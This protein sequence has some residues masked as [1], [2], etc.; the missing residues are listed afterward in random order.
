[1][2]MRTLYQ[3][4]KQDRV[5]GWIVLIKVIRRLRKFLVKVFSRS[6]D[7][8]LEFIEDIPCGTGVDNIEFDEEG[9]LWIGSHPSLLTFSAYHTRIDEPEY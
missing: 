6:T 7:G 4:S 9:N 8:S 2:V 1:M 3:D 5:H